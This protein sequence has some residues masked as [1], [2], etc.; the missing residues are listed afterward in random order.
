MSSIVTKELNITIDNSSTYCEA[1]HVDLDKET[2]AFRKYFNDST[3]GYAI[4]KDEGKELV[5]PSS[6]ARPFKADSTISCSR[7][8]GTAIVSLEFDGNS[9]H[10][11]SFTSITQRVK[12]KTDIT[13]PAVTSSTKSTQ[14]RW[15]IHGANANAQRVKYVNLKLY[16]NQYA[17]QA[18]S[19]DNTNGLQEIGVSDTA[20]Y[21]GDTVTFSAILKSG[22]IWIG[23]YSDS[24]C[25]NLVS[26]EQSYSL[27]PN[28]DLTLYAKATI[29]KIGSGVYL[30]QNGAYTQ[31]NAIWK[32][33]NGVWTK[34]DKTAIDTIKNYR[35]I[36]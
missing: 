23:W 10:S 13:D 1:D 14:I 15:H 6:T 26:D 11:E 28:S 35:L 24:A 5:F 33:T 29:S 20:P 18:V 34:T 21:Q 16:F 22:A 25:T 32:K 36:H 2:Y 31:A 12:A 9:V 27:S 3:D 17:M 19:G 4:L 8:A 30:K 7:S